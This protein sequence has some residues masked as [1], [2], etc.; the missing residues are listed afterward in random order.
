MYQTPCAAVLALAL[1]AAVPAEAQTH[2]TLS[3][4][5][6]EAKS[7]QDQL[8]YLGFC[9]SRLAFAVNKTDENLAVKIF[10]W[11]SQKQPGQKYPEGGVA[12]MTAILDLEKRAGTDHSIDLSRIDVEDML[13]Q[14]TEKKFKLPA[15]ACA[16]AGGRACA[17]ESARAAVVEPHASASSPAPA[18]PAV[19]PSAKPRKLERVPEPAANDD[20]FRGGIIKPTAPAPES[21]PAPPAHDDDTFHSG[22]LKPAYEAGPFDPKWLGKTLAF[23]GTVSSWTVDRMKTPSYII[24]YFEESPDRSFTAFSPHP[25]ILRSR[26]G[27]YFDGLWKKKIYVKGKVQPFRGA[28]GSVRILDLD[29]IEVR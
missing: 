8:N 23:Y 13:L 20:T 9:V 6:W 27:Y 12:L 29:Q 17:G 25:E 14:T 5:D 19:P 1:L 3:V 21:Q 15:T 28:K 2:S 18:K 11:Y 22:T 10:A 4:K 26:Y 16:E 24:L 7:A